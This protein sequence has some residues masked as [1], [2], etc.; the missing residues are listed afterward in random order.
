MT[1]PSGY[2]QTNLRFTGA[3]C[4]TGAEITW[5]WDISAY[6]SDVDTLAEDVF[7]AWGNEVMVYL[8]DQITLSS[9]LAKFGP[10]ATGPSAIF[11]GSVGGGDTS[12]SG[13]P[14]A[15]LL[16]R[17]NTAAGGR[18]GRGRIFV[19]GIPEAAIGPDGVVDSGKV[20]QLNTGVTDFLIVLGTPNLEPVILHQ[21]GSP[22]T[23]PTPITSI[24]AQGQ[25]ATQ[26]RRNRR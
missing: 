1:I 2:A 26:R 15:S 24:S 6:A 18:A 10:D 11:S 5:G 8:S 14:G 22:L 17:K 23:T 19:P 4:P 12:D 7:T 25:I 3:G 20:T 13:Y 16:V 21:P 9:C